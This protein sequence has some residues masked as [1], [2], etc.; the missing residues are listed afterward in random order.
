MKRLKSSEIFDLILANSKK[1]NSIFLPRIKNHETR[2]KGSFLI[3]F[4]V[5]QRAVLFQIIFSIIIY[6]ISIIFSYF[7]NII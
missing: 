7:L 3:A 5:I 4:F 1:K 2:F 6:M